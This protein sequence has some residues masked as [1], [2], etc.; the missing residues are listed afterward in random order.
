MLD[1]AMNSVVAGAKLVEITIAIDEAAKRMALTIADDGC[2][3]SSEVLAKAVDPFYTSRTTRDVGFGL[4]FLKM[5][6]EAA[7]GT[8]CITSA[9]GAGTTVNATFTL[10]HIDLMPL[11]DMAGTM[12]TLIQGSPDIDFVYTI[13]AGDD[14]F[15]LDTR[16]LR[17][18]MEG[19]PLSEAPV[20][21]FIKQFISE[22][23]EHIQQ[24]S[25]YI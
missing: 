11:G 7:G 24:R 23:S 5:A 15:V 14:E 22:N 4:S 6:A 9:A 18:M 10:G 3:M 12:A 21:L 16:E 8:F 20:V 19:V 1:V 2:G 13:K 25:I 17:I